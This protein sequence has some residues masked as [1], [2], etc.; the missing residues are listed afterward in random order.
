LP[1]PGAQRVRLRTQRIGQTGAQ[2][3]RQDQCADQNA[4]GSLLDCHAQ[5]RRP[6]HG[7][8]RSIS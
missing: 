7:K 3:V 1:Q 8:S 4:A 6:P 2:F 5:V